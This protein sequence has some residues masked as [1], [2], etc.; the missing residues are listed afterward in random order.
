MSRLID[1]DA[2]WTEI[3]SRIEECGEVLEIIESMPSAEPE[4]SQVARDIA[5]I[6]ENE[7]DMRVILERKTGQW[8]SFDSDSERYDDIECSTCGKRFT[9]D[10]DRY[11]D[12]GFIVGDLKYCPNCGCEM[13]VEHEYALEPK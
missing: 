1:A 6:I 7:Q 10:A 5:T 8:I 11:C 13:E 12:I 3:T 9:V 4:P 2:L